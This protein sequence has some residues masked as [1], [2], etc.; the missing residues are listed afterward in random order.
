MKRTLL[1]GTLCLMAL[2]MAFTSCEKVTND[3]NG[4]G[5][6]NA[7]QGGETLPGYVDLG[8]PSGTKWKS[9]NEE[10]YYTYDQA[11]ETFGDQLPTK[12][13]CLELIHNYTKENYSDTTKPKGITIINGGD[14]VFLPADGATTCD[15]ATP[16]GVGINGSYW[17]STPSA[18]DP[19]MAYGIGFGLSAHSY[20][21]VKSRCKS[22]SV[23]LVQR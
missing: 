16:L 20:V 12:E 9:V 2:A 13:Q 18:D 10:G 19:D 7:G 21:N 1:F 15:D 22:C 23:R 17:S 6:G 8:L 3:G 5:N 11:L 14:S 4:N